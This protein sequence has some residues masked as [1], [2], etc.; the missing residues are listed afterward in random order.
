MA[1]NKSLMLLLDSSAIINGLRLDEQ[2]KYLI[3]SDCFEELK[4]ME[5]R[6]LAENYFNIGILEIRDACPSSVQ[7]V[8]DFLEKL[9]D[10]KLSKQDISLIALAVEFKDCKKSFEVITDDYGL[11][12]ALKIL[13]IPFQ[14]VLQGKVKKAKKWK[15]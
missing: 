10:K 14:A 12:N 5:L 4:S 15:N 11:Q 7:K 9:G 6:L 1:A 13:K 2:L 3:T 8:L